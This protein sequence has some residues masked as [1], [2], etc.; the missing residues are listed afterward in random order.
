MLA[1]EW[2][3]KRVLLDAQLPYVLSHDLPSQ[4]DQLISAMNL[5]ISAPVVGD[6]AR[7]AS[8]YSL[9][10][11]GADRVVGG[12]DDRTVDIAP[13]YVDGSTQ[14]RLEFLAND[15]LDLGTWLRD[16]HLIPGAPVPGGLRNN[17]LM[18]DWQ[19]ASDGASVV[20]V[21]T[22]NG[23]P[24]YYDSVVDWT[25]GRFDARITAE[26]TADDNF[27]GLVFAFRHKLYGPFGQQQYYNDYGPDTFYAL[28]WK[29]TTEDM[30]FPGWGTMTAEEGLKLLRLERFE[31]RAANVMQPILWDGDY[32]WSNRLTVLA[33]NLGGDKGWEPN[34]E[35]AFSINQ[36]GGT[37]DITVERAT[38]GAIVWQTSVTDPHPLPAGQ[39]GFLNM[40]QPNVRYSWTTP[41]DDLPDGTYQLRG[42]F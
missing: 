8:T 14:L 41:V 1:V 36:S 5:T 25:G 42:I 37:I 18:G 13:E 31:G 38:D 9:L 40:G 20:H 33:S 27:I 28:T 22:Q 23:Y 6:D 15:T 3:E 16:G 32:D 26:S 2:L 30:A 39:V 24:S 17:H 21:S 29:Q 10:N 12:G 19:L 35:Y 4:T 7:N 34:V 11:L